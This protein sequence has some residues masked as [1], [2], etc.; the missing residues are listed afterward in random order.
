MEKR[1]VELDYL[2]G[3]LI[4]LMVLFHLQYIN[5][6]Y[7]YLSKFVYTFHMSGFLIISGFLTNINKPLNKFSK[8]IFKIFVPYIIFESIYVIMIFLFS[9][10]IPSSNKLYSLN[11]FGYL[12]I[13]CCHPIGTYWYLHTLVFCMIMYYFVCRIIKLKN[14]SALV[15]LVAIFYL[16]TYFTSISFSNTI[17]FLIGIS[18][19]L[20]NNRFTDIIQPSLCSVL[21]LIILSS[22]ITNLDR[23]S[24]S[25]I[26]ITI[27]VL[28]FL[29][30]VFGYLSNYAKRIFVYLGRNSLCIVVF[31]PIFTLPT[32]FVIPYFAFDNTAI[33]F[34]ILSLVFV[35]GSCLLGMKLMDA[36]RLSRFV[37][38]KEKCYVKFSDVVV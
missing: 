32:K 34:G 36:L 25:G 3:I 4:L 6:V 2:K 1:L 28:S 11:L 7:P 26:I 24:L 18:I 30:F 38:C 37:F 9:F 27:L 19:L 16:I 13:I 31:S 23:G 8:S 21:P 22:S 35:V 15:V 29:L 20:S 33:L 10:I 17:Y 5:D 12:N 14:F